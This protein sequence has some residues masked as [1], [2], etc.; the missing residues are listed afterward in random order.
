MSVAWE[1][2]RR[3]RA[4]S[5]WAARLRSGSR[6]CAALQARSPREVALVGRDGDALGGAA[7][8]LRAAGGPAVSTF[9]L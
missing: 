3:V 5:C 9:E 4:C 2:A 7:D 6:S 8:R 1:Q